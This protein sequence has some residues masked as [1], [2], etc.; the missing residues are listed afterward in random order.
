MEG[1]GCSLSYQ[2]G[3]ADLSVVT[4]VESF[5]RR[6]QGCPDQERSLDLAAHVITDSRSAALSTGPTSFFGNL[7]DRAIQ[8]TFASLYREP[9][10]LSSRRSALNALV[11]HLLYVVVDHLVSRDLSAHT[12]TISTV[13][14]ALKLRNLL[15][16]RTRHIADDPSLSRL[17][18]WLRIGKILEAA[19]QLARSL[20]PGCFMTTAMVA[21]DLAHAEKN[22]PG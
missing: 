19:R 9:R 5:L 6:A 14:S 22:I 4:R 12:R 21:I 17:S 1:C 11:G 16:D 10:A 15:I 2:P 8:A 20:I 7:A 18:G 3:L 13:Q